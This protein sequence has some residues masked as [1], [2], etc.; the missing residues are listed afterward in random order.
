[1]ATPDEVSSPLFDSPSAGAD[2]AGAR[3]LLAAEQARKRRQR[4][5][6]LLLLIVAIIAFLIY[7]ALT[8]ETPIPGISS[9]V[10]Q[11]ESTIYGVAQPMGVAVSPDGDRVYVTESGGRR[12]VRVYDSSGKEV[13]TLKPPGHRGEW[14]LPVYV[15]VNPESGDVYVSDRL[16]EDVDV[17]D[18]EGEYLRAFRPDGPLGKGA[19]PLGLAFGPEED[20]YMTDVGG[21]RKDHRVLVFGDGEEPLRRIG[22]RGAFWFPNGL[23]VDEEGDVYVADSNNGRLAILDPDGKLVASIQRGVGDGDLGL[24]RG[25]AIHDGKLYV[26][27]TTAHVAKVYDLG[28]DVTEVPTYIGSFGGEGFAD[29]TFQYPNGIAIDGDGRIYVTDRENNRVQIW[30]Y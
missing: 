5:V 16:R 4:K 22:A 13:D 30:T 19:N 17:Y 11:Y 18:E 12:L 9:Q 3:N 29:G 23:A 20:L 6:A 15:A 2:G 24:P 27:D 14:R 7:R 1:M 8:G 21:G 10:P 28:D 25:V 26:V